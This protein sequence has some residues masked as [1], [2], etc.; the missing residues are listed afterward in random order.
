VEVAPI[1][2]VD[3]RDHKN[4]LARETRQRVAP[5]PATASSD[6][7]RIL[8]IMR[9]THAIGQVVGYLHLSA[10]IRS[11]PIPAPVRQARSGLSPATTKATAIRKATTAPILALTYHMMV[12]HDRA[13][14]CATARSD[15]PLRLIPVLELEGVSNLLVSEGRRVQPPQV[16]AGAAVG[17][18]GHGLIV[19]CNTGGIN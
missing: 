12:L 9:H 7:A 4:S 15:D 16:H 18:L 2:H 5:P 10:T 3:H 1:S 17:L 13:G 6:K 19:S 8:W 11:S 14:K